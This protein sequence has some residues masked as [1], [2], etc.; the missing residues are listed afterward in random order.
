MSH[1]KYLT[2]Y[3]AALQEKVKQLIAED[4]LGAYLVARYPNTHEV[5]TD[6]A[7]YA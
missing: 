7:L 1:L 4:Q 6:R 2:G 3:P 5:Q